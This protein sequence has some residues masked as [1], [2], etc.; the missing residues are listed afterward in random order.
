MP[1]KCSV[2]GKY[3]IGLCPDVK[4]YIRTAEGSSRSRRCGTA[5]GLFGPFGGVT[6]MSAKAQLFADVWMRKSIGRG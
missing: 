1:V 5:C 4:M 3:H 2:C 6:G